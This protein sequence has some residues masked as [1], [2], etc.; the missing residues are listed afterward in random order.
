MCSCHFLPGSETTNLWKA[1][2]LLGKTQLGPPSSAK[3]LSEVDKGISINANGENK[4]KIKDK[5]FKVVRPK[6]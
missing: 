6:G 2:F 1:M 3:M 4:N 5:I